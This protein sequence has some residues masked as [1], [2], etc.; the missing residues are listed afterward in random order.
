MKYVLKSAR[1]FEVS[2]YSVIPST[3]SLTLHLWH[4]TLVTSSPWQVKNS[5]LPLVAHQG[6][7]ALPLCH[8]LQLRI[9]RCRSSGVGTMALLATV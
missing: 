4:L 5:W 3:Q 2:F 9:Q 6:A 8:P 1:A 7:A